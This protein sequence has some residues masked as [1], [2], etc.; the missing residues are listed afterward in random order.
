MREFLNFIEYYKGNIPLI[1]SVPHGGELNCNIL[2][3]RTTGILG[4]DKRTIDLARE[5]IDFLS[6]ANKSSSKNSMNP[7]YIISK[8]RRSK[9][10]FNRPEKEA[11]LGESEISKQIYQYYHA[12]IKENIEDNI[13]KFN[14]SLLVD[15]HGFERHKRPPGFRDVDLIIGTDNLRS[16]YST[17]I[18]R[19]EWSETLRG[20][21]VKKFIE[22]TIPI[23][24]GHPNRK[25]YIL[26]GGFITSAYGAS[27]IIKSRA[28]QIE[29][30]DRI[31]VQDTHL[32]KKVLK[33]LTS[34]LIE[35]IQPRVCFEKL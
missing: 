12:K 24:P 32:K 31:R 4:I 14:Y 15:I 28:M 3:K 26:T 6:T 29:F 8:L 34:V 19:K 27:Q 20:K 11:F 30:S 1:L 5:L 23:A 18:S 21:L 35:E 7:S 17:P 22:L 13:H 25:E 2:P 16:L 9:I 33:A 10:D